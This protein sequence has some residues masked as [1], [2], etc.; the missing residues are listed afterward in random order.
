MN[1]ELST[2]GVNSSVDNGRGSKDDQ[3]LSL[4]KTYSDEIEADQGKNSP[5]DI[6]SEHSQKAIAAKA[7]FKRL[8]AT[9]SKTEQ[10]AMDAWLAERAD[11]TELMYI[12]RDEDWENTD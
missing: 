3:L 1:P 5:G 2:G 7:A 9:L 8:Y 12:K 6:L 4:L 10:V 11:A